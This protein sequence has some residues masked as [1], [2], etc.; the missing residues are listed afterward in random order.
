MRV[1]IVHPCKGFYGGAEEVVAKFIQTVSE[2]D[3]QCMLVSK[4]IPTRFR[5]MPGRYEIYNASNWFDFRQMTQSELRY[6]DLTI[7]FNFPASLALWPTKKP[8]IWYC[9]EPPELF[10]T[11]YRA[12]IEAFHR[13]WLKSANV[14]YAVADIQNAQ[15]L[16]VRYPISSLEVIPYGIDYNFW[17]QGIRTEA[18]SLRL[19]QVGTISPY[20]RQIDSIQILTQL[21]LAG[22]DA[23]LTLVGAVTDNDYDQLLKDRL[24]KSDTLVP[25]VADR[26]TRLGLLTP[27]QTREEYYRHDLLLHPVQYQGGWL[28]PFEA[29]CAKLPVLVSRRCAASSVINTQRLGLTFA[30]ISAALDIIL[31]RR[32]DDATRIERAAEYVKTQLTWD[33]FTNSIINLGIRNLE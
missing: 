28:T 10:T 26:V 7:A 29:M 30:G 15:A 4:D 23:H 18:K 17:S 13:Y 5:S 27:E 8:F 11:W 25:G 33:R 9:N 22:I 19:L 32:Y 3:N 20:K 21:V 6:A 16:Q 24:T 1:L 31:T 12:G 2:R 14:A